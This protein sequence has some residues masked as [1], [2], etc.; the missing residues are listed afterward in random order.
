MKDLFFVCGQALEHVS[1]GR[2]GR[3]DHLDTTSI[4]NCCCEE[5]QPH[6]SCPRRPRGGQK[7]STESTSGTGQEVKRLE[8]EVRG[9]G[10][11]LLC[12]IRWS[13]MFSHSL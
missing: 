8:A 3:P 6:C 1:A 2:E 7:K 9:A 5:F 13:E 12:L 4:T 11:R 10:E